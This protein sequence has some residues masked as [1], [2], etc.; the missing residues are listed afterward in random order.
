MTPISLSTS[1]RSLRL[2][3]FIVFFPNISYTYA[4]ALD[5]LG[6]STLRERRHYLDAFFFF[7]QVCRG[8]K[9]CSSLLRNI[10]LHVP[11]SNLREF[12]L[13]GACPYDK[14]CPSAWCASAANVVGKD[15]DIFAIGEVSL[16]DIY[17]R[18]PKRV[19][20]FRTQL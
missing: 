8:F 1:G 19:D 3:A 5:K 17:K 6:L 14:H 10:S 16:N 11:P 4:V 15:L 9:S 20:I 7:V 2:S 18:Q 13:F 12:S